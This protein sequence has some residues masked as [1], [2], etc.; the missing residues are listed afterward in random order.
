M[1]TP[2]LQPCTARLARNTG[3]A[4]RKILGSAVESNNTPPQ[5]IMTPYWRTVMQTTTRSTPGHTK[6]DHTHNNLWAPITIEEAKGSLPSKGAAPGPDLITFNDVRA[7]SHEDLSLFLNL[8]MLCDHPPLK[9][10]ESRTRLIPK[11]ADAPAPGDYRPISVSSVVIRCL[12]KVL[13][14]R[15][16]DQISINEEQTAFRPVDGC[17]LNVYLVDL[18]LRY[19][20]T[21]SK[22]LYMATLDLSKAYDSVTHESIQD[23]LYQYGFPE[24]MINHIMGVYHHSTS[25]LATSENIPQEK[26]SVIDAKCKFKCGAHTLPAITRSTEWTYLG[27]PFTPEGR[28]SSNPLNQLQDSI[29][30][31]YT[32]NSPWVERP[33]ASS[34]SSMPSP[35]GLPGGGY[36]YLLTHQTHTSTPT[37]G[38]EGLVSPRSAGRSQKCACAQRPRDPD[39]LELHQERLASK[40]HTS[41]DGA[42]LAASAQ[43]PQQHRWITE[44]TTFLSGA[45]FVNLNKLRINALPSRSRCARGRPK[46]DRF[47]R[48]DCQERKQQTT[49]CKGVPGHTAPG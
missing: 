18:A 39:G 23:T 33:S 26:K 2:T 9:M 40:L 22:P 15:V 46:K 1:E 17:S 11:K 12:H 10:L 19:H 49:S 31:G 47:C 28:H 38:T 29:E 3:R 45:D 16:T 27:V 8:L 30:R 36:T 35:V 4:I 32:T 42:A 13:A 21:Q 14:K 48:A 37:T 5:D 20:R 43:V 6:P 24:P 41:V 44:G 34:G 25:K 7:L